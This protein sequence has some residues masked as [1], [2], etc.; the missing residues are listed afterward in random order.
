MNI[1]PSSPNQRGL[2]AL[3][4]KQQGKTLAEIADY[5]RVTRERARQILLRAEADVKT[6]RKHEELQKRCTALLKRPEVPAEILGMTIDYL[7]LS[8]RASNCLTKANVKTIG[9]LIGKTSIGLSKIYIMGKKT[10]DEIVLAL[11]EVGLSLADTPV[12]FHQRRLPPVSASMRYI[13]TK[14]GWSETVY[15]EWKFGY[16]GEPMNWEEAA[17]LELKRKQWLGI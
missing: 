6:R 17:I 11:D 1:Q 4:L 9:D 2:Q 13:L 5:L 14:R 7:N 15:R 12:R 16:D 10:L 8:A 3:E